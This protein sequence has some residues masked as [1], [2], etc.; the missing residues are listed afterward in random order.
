MIAATVN[1][2]EDSEFTK[3]NGLKALGIEN[4]LLHSGHIDVILVLLQAHQHLQAVQA[5]VTWV[6]C[7]FNV[8]NADPI[9]LMDYCPSRQVNI[10]LYASL[11]EARV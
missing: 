11:L 4:G 2:V 1:K 3:M 10:S 8:Q 7:S 9:R 5:M 6:K